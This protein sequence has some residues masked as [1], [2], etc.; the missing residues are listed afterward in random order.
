M[1]RITVTAVFAAFL[2]AA[3][4]GDTCSTEEESTIPALV[5][6]RKRGPISREVSHLFD[7]EHPFKCLELTGRIEDVFHDETNAR[8]IFIVVR[9]GDRIFHATLRNSPKTESELQELIGA[10]A[11][12]C[13]IVD[14]SYD[15]KRSQ[16]GPT[17]YLLSPDDIRVTNPAPSDR[18]AVPEIGDL[19]HLPPQEIAAIGLRRAVGR[20]RAVWQGRSV[21]IETTN[22]VPLVRL[23]LADTK[24]PRIGDFIEALGH[25]ETDMYRINLSRAI[26][27]AAPSRP[28][29]PEPPVRDVTDTDIFEAHGPVPGIWSE[30]YGKPIRI[31]GHVLSDIDT[32]GRFLIQ[33]GKHTLP[34]DTSALDELAAAPVGSTVRVSGPCLM[35]IENWR[36][37]AAFPRIQG[38]FIAL[39]SPTDVTVLSRP[40]WWTTGRLLAVIGALALALIAALLWSR[41]L[42]IAAARLGIRLMHEELKKTKSDLRIAERT[43]LAAE[44]HDSL[45]QVLTGIA[46]EVEAAKN[47]KKPVPDEVRQHLDFAASALRFCRNDIRYRLWDLRNMALD[48]PDMNKAILKTLAPHV[49]GT[50][51]AVRFNVSRSRIS[52]NTAQALLKA[53]RELSINAIRHG[54]ATS[55]KI[56]GDLDDGWLKC[57]VRDNGCGFDPDTAP[58]M[59]EGHFGLQGV[60]ERIASVGGSISIS[61]RPGAGTKVTISIKSNGF[62]I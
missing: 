21:L 24:P 40:P 26:W 19:R 52:D 49:K 31:E 28:D 13:G 44:L 58:G 5:G 56:A 14:P 11:V 60:R 22:A 35:E 36:P 1:M 59:N 29:R 9:S 51:L 62:N 43:H 47:V 55:L 61:S 50:K 27:R 25:P 30:L 57:S 3:A 42:K 38:V 34:V 54:G 32:N 6:I 39:R 4:L 8:Y 2:L 41:S 20:V 37:N 45:S 33:S 12:F 46:M 17:F 53:I 10:Q 16:I 7:N 18:F 15:N 48:E 23:D